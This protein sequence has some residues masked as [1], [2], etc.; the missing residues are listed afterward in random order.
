MIKIYFKTAWRNILKK[1]FHAVI[2]IIGLVSS[3][4]FVL[5]I[6]AYI[7]QAYQ[8]NSGLRH[9]DRQYVLQSE[10]KKPGIGL[11]L[12]TVGALPKALKEEY[13]HLVANYYRIDGLT[14]IVSHEEEVYEES[15]SLGDSTMLDMFGFELFEGNTRTA[16]AAPF[17]VVITQ[18][19]AIKYFGKTDVLG[20]N[21]TI[22]NF[23]GEQHDFTI[24]GIM[25]PTVQNSVMELNTAMKASIF[26][27]IASEQYFGRNID[28]WNNLWIAAFIELQEN[29]QPAQLKHPIETLLTQHADKQIVENLIPKLKSL[30]SY[31]LDD[32]GGAIKQLIQ[33]LIWIAGFLIIMA[34]VNFINFTVSQSFTRLKE[35]GIRKTMGGSKGQL[36]LQLIT[37]YML[38]VAIAGLIALGLYPVLS[39]LFESVMMTHLPSIQELPAPFFGYF[40]LAVFFLGLLSG[41]YPAFKLSQNGLLKS[42]K[43]QLSYTGQKPLLR[44]ILLFVQ[45]AVTIVVLIS[46]IV[47]SRQINIFMKGDLGY[48]KD[49]LITVQSPRDWSEK[50]LHKME[51]V[52]DELKALPDVEDI[53]LSYGVPGSFADGIQQIQKGSDQQVDA[54]MITSDAHFSSTYGI[55]LLAGQFFNTHEGVDSDRSRLVINLKAAYALGFDTAEEAIGQPISLFGNQFNGTIVGVTDNFYTNSMHSASPPIIWFSVKNNNQYR[56]LSIRLKA[57]STVEALTSLETKWK[58]LMPDAPFEFRF[59]D[60]TIQ[61]MYTIEL[62]LQRA[63][64]V[65]SAISIIIIALGI[66]GLTVLAINLRLKEIS[67]RKLLG[68]STQNMISLFGKE[69]YFT[70]FIALLVGCPLVYMMMD[71]WL[72]NYILRTELHIGIF[73]L[74]IIGLILLLFIIIGSIVFRATKA[75]PVD[76]LRDE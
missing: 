61:N 9:K 14:C 11:D 41:I 8:V 7:W 31:Y 49:Y 40:A 75:N 73:V 45:F 1:K 2:N 43:N 26:L 74:P 21:L 39:P 35:I 64:Q 27:P 3:M 51:L 53:S 50:G 13:P 67:I 65:A 10:Y 47:I 28:N 24:T 16:L 29:V 6:A 4:S 5:L 54:L 42:L 17:S 46:S 59:M 25:K 63:S 38:I 56:F 15:V 70:F 32:N 18:A 68:A 58:Q 34:V 57:G 37:E 71:K 12:T 48:D 60:D 22:R 69:F 23:A 72:S 76:T 30:S 52:R 66:I 55:P 44:R 36:I 33:I 20:R 62:Q 19:T